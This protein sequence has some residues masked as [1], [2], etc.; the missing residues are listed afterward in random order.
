MEFWIG[1]SVF[2]R[3]K[4][5]ILPRYKRGRSEVMGG[6]NDGT[7]WEN[8]GTGCENDGTGWANDAFA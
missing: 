1:S 6:L 3:C 8:D 4:R 2:M 7:G 5:I